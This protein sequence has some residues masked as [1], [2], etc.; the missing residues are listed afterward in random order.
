MVGG[1]G[2]NLGLESGYLGRICLWFSSVSP[3][4]AMTVG[5]TSEAGSRSFHSW[6][7]YLITHYIITLNN[8]TNRKCKKEHRKIKEYDV[9]ASSFGTKLWRI[10]RVSH[11]SAK[12][13]VTIFK[14]TW[15]WDVN[16]TGFLDFLHCP[17][18]QKLENTAF[19]KLDQFP[20]SGER[21]RHLV[22]W[23]S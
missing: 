10:F 16:N 22:C 19:R 7:L 11:V 13:A 21:G 3:W 4:N 8:I 2:S 5:P 14:V 12:L 20:S 17:V 1:L 6:S 18:F 23:V 9:M 15:L